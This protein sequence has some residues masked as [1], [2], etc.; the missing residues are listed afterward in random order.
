MATATGKTAKVAAAPETASTS[1][2]SCPRWLTKAD[3]TRDYY[4][5]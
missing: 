4:S 1:V 3:K 5:K 2:R